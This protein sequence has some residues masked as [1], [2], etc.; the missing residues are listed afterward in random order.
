MP[1]DQKHAAID[2]AASVFVPHSGQNFAPAANSYSQLAHFV[3]SCDVP[4]SEQ[5]LAPSRS[6][7]P[8]FTQ[9]TF[10][11][12]IFPPQSAQNLAAGLFCFPQFGHAT[13]AALPPDP[14]CALPPPN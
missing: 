11:T 9:G 2:Y 5:N 13:V 7:A 1:F 6:W 3:F 4:H 8:H 12:S 10:A 14:P